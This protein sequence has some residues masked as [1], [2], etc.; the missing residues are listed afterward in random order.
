VAHPIPHHPS[1]EEA[2][3]ASAQAGDE[4]AFGRLLERHLRELE[5][6]CW[7]M[8]G[9]PDAVKHA[10]ADTV[11]T[12]WRERAVLEPETSVRV[13]LHRV[14]VRTCCEV[15]GDPMSL[16]SGDRLTCEDS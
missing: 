12:A 11:L 14:A 2:L 3:L 5:H 4:S 15:A 16:D 7:L 1:D 9:D 10:I 13:W 6:C 8:L